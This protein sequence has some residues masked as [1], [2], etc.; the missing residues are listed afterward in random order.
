MVDFSKLNS[1]NKIQNAEEG[2]KKIFT[3]DEQDLFNNDL[4]KTDIKNVQKA[5]E[6]LVKIKKANELRKKNAALLL[7]LET[8]QEKNGGRGSEIYRALNAKRLVKNTMNLL[9]I[10]G[11]DFPEDKTKRE[12]RIKQLEKELSSK[13]AEKAILDIYLTPLEEQLESAILELNK[14]KKVK[15][16]VESLSQILSGATDPEITFRNVPN[17][18]LSSIDNQINGKVNDY[19]T[20]TNLKSDTPPKIADGTSAQAILNT[21]NGYLTAIVKNKGAKKSGAGRKYEKTKIRADYFNNRIYHAKFNLINNWDNIG[22]GVLKALREFGIDKLKAIIAA[23]GATGTQKTRLEKIAKRIVKCIHWN[24][25]IGGKDYQFTMLRG[26]GKETNKGWADKFDNFQKSLLKKKT[27]E[28]PYVQAVDWEDVFEFMLSVFPLGTDGS[29]ANKDYLDKKN[30]ANYLAPEKES[31]G[32]SKKIWIKGYSDVPTTAG[33]SIAEHATKSSTPSIVKSELKVANQIPADWTFKSIIQLFYDAFDPFVNFGTKKWKDP[34]ATTSIDEEWENMKNEL[35]FC[36]TMRELL[37]ALGVSTQINEFDDYLL[38]I[39]DRAEKAKITGTDRKELIE[40]NNAKS[41]LLLLEGSKAGGGASFL[42]DVA[43]G[44]IWGD[45]Y[46]E[47]RS[48]LL[49]RIV[50][51]AETKVSLVE[52]ETKGIREQV[53]KNKEKMLLLDH[54]ISSKKREIQ[55]L[56][57]LDD[58]KD[59]PL[60]DKKEDFNKVYNKKNQNEKWLLQEIKKMRAL[61][62]IIEESMDAAGE[63]FKNEFGDKRTEL[64]SLHEEVVSIYGK[65]G[66]DFEAIINQTDDRLPS[67]GVKEILKRLEDETTGTESLETIASYYKDLEEKIKLDEKEQLYYDTVKKG[68]SEPDKFKDKPTSTLKLPDLVETLKGEKDLKET[69]LTTL[70]AWQSTTNFKEKA[71]IEEL[72]KKYKPGSKEKDQKS[73]EFKEHLKHEKWGGDWGGKKIEGDDYWETF[74]KESPAFI[75]GAIKHFEWE[76][77][78]EENK[79]KVTDEMEEANKWESTDKKKKA[80]PAD[81]KKWDIKKAAHIAQFLYLKAEN[82]SGEQLVKNVMNVEDKPE[83]DEKDKPE[84]NGGDK[85]M[86][87]GKEWFGF[88]NTGKSLLAYGLILVA[89]VGIGGAIFW[90]QIKEWWS[91]PAEEEGRI[92]EE[93]EAKE[94]V[95][96]E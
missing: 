4:I 22:Y 66:R 92:G 27:D 95:E 26:E 17:T 6:L 51:R 65:I 28:Y 20:D 34:S 59:K 39:A 47:S 73:G 89:V 30:D 18:K 90:K 72:V 36:K 80:D 56:K 23:S 12:A 69:D 45:N 21:A 15:A 71:K 46:N 81:D 58:S 43:E 10:L 76:N 25:E 70:T 93:G 96:N 68:I 16:K 14:V 48:V 91:G 87:W 24:E 13:R 67:S 11:D 1:L 32:W 85:K 55:I 8:E 63:N 86:G 44:K 40:G 37:L 78:T 29:V 61:L 49:A 75:I 88:G 94:E 52:E 53:G 62:T 19:S 35:R 5:A 83:D 82:K 54:E 9:S 64:D 33:I 50:E 79:K 7:E 57:E 3:K 2:G 74:V 84:Q 60:P 38:D 31:E 77:D 41:A 42:K